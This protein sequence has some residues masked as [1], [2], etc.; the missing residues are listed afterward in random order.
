MMKLKMLLF[1]LLLCNVMWAS[2]VIVTKDSK[3]IDAK[4]TE[5]TSSEVKYKKANALDGP[6]FTLPTSEIQT[7]VY[8]NG[9]VSTFNQEATKKGTYQLYDENVTLGFKR[10]NGKKVS[11]ADYADYLKEHCTPAYNKFRKGQNLY[12]AGWTCL[13]AG[14]ACEI[15]GGVISGI[16]GA[17]NAL[18]YTLTGSLAVVAGVPLLITGAVTRGRSIS[19]YETECKGKTAMELNFGFTKNGVGLA[20]NF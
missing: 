16:S 8:D 13:I 15:T 6:T 18:P 1:A 17:T 20:L 19:V 9:D 11:S 4:V 12:V 3:K 5:V 7:I 10:I 2:D 14:V